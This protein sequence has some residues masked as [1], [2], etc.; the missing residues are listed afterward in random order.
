MIIVDVRECRDDPDHPSYVFFPQ[1]DE[2]GKHVGGCDA[3]EFL[4]MGTSY[5]YDFEVR[6]PFKPGEEVT[7]LRVERKR[8]GDLVGSFDKIERQTS[9]VDAIVVEFDPDDI[10]ATLTRDERGMVGRSMKRLARLGAE[11]LWVIPSLGPSSTL[12][13]LRYIESG[14]ARRKG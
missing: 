10:E 6:Y 8:L 4:K 5:S 11:G 14:R 1:F 9:Y 7:P 12:E 3:R 13:I 2:N